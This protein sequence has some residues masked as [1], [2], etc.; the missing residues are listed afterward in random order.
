MDI[1]DD[2]LA[3]L[4]QNILAV[5]AIVTAGILFLLM[6]L[7]RWHR[8]LKRDFPVEFRQLSA[9]GE[10][11]TTGDPRKLIRSLLF[12]LLRRRHEKVRNSSFVMAASH[13]R[14]VVILCLG[15]ILATVVYVAVNYEQYGDEWESFQRNLK[16]PN[17]A[18]DEKIEVAIEIYD[19]GEYATVIGILDEVIGNNPESVDAHYYRALAYE[20]LHQ[21]KA[22][23]AGFQTVAELAPEHFN[24]YVHINYLYVLRGR[25]REIL[26]WWDRYL[27][28]V[29]DN[30]K[31]LLQRGGAYYQVN[32][33]EL[34]QADWTRACELGVSEGCE[35]L[36]MLADIVN[37]Q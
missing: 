14:Q 13:A 20:K 37:Q 25:Y 8:S 7:Y 34:A 5:M 24:S 10:L 26:P 11:E 17:M 1:L 4:P 27:E 6:T 19:E 12:Y 36:Q 29:P 31:A 32:E 22:A 3:A 2:V 28:R 16:L 30:G 23:L 33:V 9:S 18:P 35:W 15:V 21:Y